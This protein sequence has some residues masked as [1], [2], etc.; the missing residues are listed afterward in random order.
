MAK[1]LNL[2]GELRRTAPS[3]QVFDF[4]DLTI[5]LFNRN[6]EYS[7]G[8]PYFDGRPQK[9]SVLQL[10]F[11]IETPLARL[12]EYSDLVAM[13]PHRETNGSYTALANGN[14]D[15]ILVAR[16]PSAD[17]LKL[18]GEKKM[19]FDA[20]PV[21]KD[22]LVFVGNAQ[23]RIEGLSLEQIRGIYSGRIQNWKEVG[24]DDKE[25]Y[26]ITRGAN[27]GSQELLETRVM[28]NQ[29]VINGK[30]R[31][32]SSMSGTFD[33]V[34]KNDNS[35]AY[36]V[37]YY[38]RIMNPREKLKPL[39]INGVLPTSQTIANGKYPLIEPV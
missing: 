30:N 20:R 17:E 33:M 8:Q 18:A 24:G 39:A 32:A 27:S 35:V 16:L 38:E 37:F 19:S 29:P 2:Q 23:N 25:I 11:P 9:S 15:L 10:A 5:P 36:S 6:T 12:Q 1:A 22:A 14:V 4:F 34:E 13:N 31:V 28:Q 21:A 26:A 3:P 7:K